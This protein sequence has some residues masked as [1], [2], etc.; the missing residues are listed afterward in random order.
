MFLF[1]SLASRKR[2]PKKAKNDDKVTFLERFSQ[3]YLVTQRNFCNFAVDLRQICFLC[4]LP[5]A[6][7]TP[8]GV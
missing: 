6:F 2:T 7:V 5:R 1:L 3:K 4:L 8:Q